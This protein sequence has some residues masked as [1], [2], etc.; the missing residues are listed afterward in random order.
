MF[1]SLSKK[2]S[3]SAVIKS[4]SLL[5]RKDQIKLV[6]IALIQVFMGILDL[7]GVFAIG[8]LGALAVQGIESRKPGNRV[9]EVLRL[10]HLQNLSFSSQVA[11]LGISAGVVLVLKT[12]VSIFFTRRVF[13]F[14]SAKGS[15]ISADLV[16]KVLSQNLLKVQEKTTQEIL[17]MISEGVPGILTG[18][19]ATSINM[20]S[21]LAMLFIMS[22]G[23]AIV[24]PSIA[25]ITFLLFFAV[26][27]ILHKLLQVRSKELGVVLNE[28]SV[29]SSEKIIEVLN[30][31]RE[32][33]V[34]NRRQFYSEN[35]R[36][37]RFKLGSVIAEQ[38]FQ[39]YIS[40]YVIEM[41]AILG[42]LGLAGYEFGTKNAV[43]AVSVLAVFMAASA[44]IS[45]AA[46]RIQQGLLV[47]RKNSGLSQS[48]F[49]L[50]DE[51]DKAIIPNEKIENPDF[52]Y[53]SFAP[54]LYLS[55]V[56]F[57]YEDSDKFAI[58]DLSLKISAGTSVAVVGPSGAGKTTLIDLILGVLQPQSGSV[59]ISKVSP[60]E[61][62]RKWSGAISY[63]PQ[64]V[65][66]SSGS[67]RDN[68]SLG[69]GKEFA[70]DERV[71]EALDLARM[72]DVVQNLPQGLDSPV[73]EAGSNLSGGQ[74]QRLGIA[75]ALFTK[76]KLLVLDEATS[77]LDG[78]TESDIS[79]SI[80]SLSNDVT[81]IIVAHRLST[82][83][84]VSKVI[85]MEEGRI[86]AEGNIDEVRKSVPD[87][88]RQASLMGL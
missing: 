69:Y 88:D 12:A 49:N 41:S 1:E 70:S 11:I 18:I 31:Y 47:I 60:P 46:L 68:V 67:I 9:G 29:A 57:D 80:A 3:G 44:R 16:S 50:I 14:L 62:S 64:N 26:A 61:A 78:Q 43:H 20:T 34:R 30:S 15:Q 71:W 5:P 8:S 42:S 24:D 74:R 10:L 63:V 79:E 84:N 45:P 87:F 76:P 72:K 58:K 53:E 33:L 13:F 52:T 2:F 73:G 56:S 17:Y 83:R 21:D 77:A 19:L 59:R 4:A 23:L 66:I 6:V 86:K 81:V 35:I 28:Y 32:T 55:N 39:P 48:T 22:L 37:L 27:L 51:M 85:Y 7:V 82:I 75:R 36:D 40:K 25:V 38:S 54:E 65:F